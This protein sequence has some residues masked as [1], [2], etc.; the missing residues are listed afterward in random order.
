M[1]FHWSMARTIAWFLAFFKNF[2][3]ALFLTT[4]NVVASVVSCVFFSLNKFPPQ[5]LGR[6]LVVNKQARDPMKRWTWHIKIGETSSYLW[7]IPLMKPFSSHV[8]SLSLVAP[9]FFFLARELL[10]LDFARFLNVTNSFRRFLMI[11]DEEQKQLQ[12]KI[13]WIVKTF[14]TFS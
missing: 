6:G 1:L 8:P 12:G 13:I 9:T 7:I 3:L 14:L 11:G 5:V 2:K 10:V 4:Y